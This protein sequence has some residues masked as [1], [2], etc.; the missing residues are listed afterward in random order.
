MK[1]GNLDKTQGNGQTPLG[2]RQR[3]LLSESAR[4]EEELLPDFVRPMLFFSAAALAAFV[5]WAGLTQI[6]EVARAPGE[7][8]PISK[9]KVVQHLDGGVITEIPVEER[10]LVQEGQVLLRMD[11]SQA[12]ADLHQMEARQVAL[13]LRAERL[14]AFAEGRKA[15]L[16]ALAGDHP[17]LLANQKQIYRTQVETRSSTLSIL[18]HQIQQKT[19]RLSQL[20]NSRTSAKEHLRL[21]DELSTM[22]E[23]LASRRLVNRTVLLETR[24]AKVTASGEVDRLNEEILVSG[25]ELAE[26]KSRRADTFNQLQRDALNE[27]GAVRA[28]SA[29]VEES[30]KRLKAKVARLVVRAPHRGLIQDLKVQ[31]VGQVI[32]PGALLMQVV[33]D[34]APLEAEVRIAPK[35]IGHIR[36]GQP[37]NLRVSSFEYTRFGYAAGTLKRISASSVTDPQTNQLFYRGW[38]ALTNPYVGNTPGKYLLQPGMSLEADIIT[39]EKT[40]LTYLVKPVADAFAQAF[41]ER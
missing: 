16:D 34:D 33:P 2:R 21:T 25:Q 7:I 39:G 3:N 36:V 11:G 22:R 8:L 6:K 27:M 26:V 41:R 38:V 17:D 10:M 24:R 14:S 4:I 15:N 23:D 12:L 5:L 35:D 1:L 13:R 18:D 31:T 40:L 20:E 32:Q 30:L 29:E 9:I 37:V 19:Q 28:E